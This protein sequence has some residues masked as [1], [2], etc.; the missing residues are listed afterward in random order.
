M[1]NTNKKKKII[2]ISLI[3]LLALLAIIS[4]TIVIR[5]NVTVD[6]EYAT[7]VNNANSPLIAS[8]IKSGV[9]IDGIT[10]T[11]N[12]LNTSDAT[13][14]AADIVKGK[15]AYVNGKKITGTLVP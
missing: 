11:L 9:K 5:N 14:T 7:T 2:I 4:S 13:A 15:T 8:Y 6:N 10:G 3:V 1:K 12:V